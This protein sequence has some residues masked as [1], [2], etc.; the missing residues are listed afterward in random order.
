M[1]KRKDRIV[2]AALELLDEGGV[3]NVTTK[4]L[5]KKQGI[6]E[7]ALYRHFENKHAILVEIIREFSSYDDKI[8]NTI[9]DQ[10][11]NGIDV[12]EYYIDRFTELFQNYSEL[13]TVLCSFD[14]YF[15]SVDTKNMMTEVI[16]NREKFLEG[17]LRQHPI[18]NS[19][20]TAEMLSQLINDLLHAEVF[21]WRLQDKKYD[22][23]SAVRKKVLQLIKCK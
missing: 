12:I 8:M 21:R 11:M 20:I 16:M 9:K 4:N 17:W 14:L 15:Y 18:E 7:P 13:A 22:L 5:A 1:I 19:N 2:I 3:L 23:N 6:T 10:N